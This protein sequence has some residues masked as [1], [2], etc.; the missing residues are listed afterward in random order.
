H[1]VGQGVVDLHQPEW[2]LLREMADDPAQLSACVP[3]ALAA[4]EHLA[5][6]KGCE[7]L[8]NSLVAWSAQ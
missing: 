4:A 7:A 2:L 3:S 1:D 8:R 5:R 6:V